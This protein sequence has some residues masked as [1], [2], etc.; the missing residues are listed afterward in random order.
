MEEVKIKP[1]DCMK[2][3]SCHS[4]CQ[5]H[6]RLHAWEGLV[7]GSDTSDLV[8][9]TSEVSCVDAVFLPR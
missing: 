5:V 6:M 8:T 7:G 2:P 1:P 3:A 9:P 4:L